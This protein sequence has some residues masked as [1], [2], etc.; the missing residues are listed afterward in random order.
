VTALPA[1]A[2]KTSARG[3]VNRE[4]VRK[5]RPILVPLIGERAFEYC[6]RTQYFAKFL[7]CPLVV[8]LGAIIGAA[9]T[10]GAV[11]IALASIWGICVLYCLVGLPVLF[12]WMKKAARL[13]SGKLSAE[14]GYPIRIRGA[15]GLLAVEV[16][17]RQTDRAM[18]RYRDRN[19]MAH[20]PGESDAAEGSDHQR[21]GAAP[22]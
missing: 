11:Q 1:S 20:Q 12:V 7:V 14:L 10:K 19:P 3:S 2:V 8:G 21:P 18:Q 4:M 13:A 6:V 16:W 17:K 22:R 5:T 9:F 15:G